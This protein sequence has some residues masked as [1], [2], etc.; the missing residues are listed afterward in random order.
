MSEST[1][2]NNADLIDIAQK[3]VEI[4]DRIYSLE[5][6]DHNGHLEVVPLRINQAGAI[7]VA[8]DVIAESERRAAG[9]IR[10]EGTVELGAVGDFIAYVNRYKTPDS[11]VFAPANPP[12]VTAVFDYH[13]PTNG[14]APE[15]Y[16]ASW[17]RD[18]ASYQCPLSRQWRLWTGAENKPQGQVAFGD[19]LEANQSDLGTRE[20][21]ASATQMIEV[22]RNL[23]IHSAGK[24]QR[25]IDPTTG[26]GT[27]VVKDEHDAATSTKIPKGFA[28]AIPVFEGDET[29][30]PVEALLRFTMNGGTPQ[31]AYLLQNKEKCLEHALAQLR[32]RVTKDCGIPVFVGT[33][34]ATR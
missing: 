6:V 7:E 19:F 15:G 29:L 16:E 27:L 2:T 33:P 18:R 25:T 4:K 30:Y 34:P 1:T 31:F 32:E 11:I 9:P 8:K 28:L 17:C 13:R 10:R 5:A 20:G 14:K 24:F 12:G 26:T 21:F 23:V 3:A 22:A